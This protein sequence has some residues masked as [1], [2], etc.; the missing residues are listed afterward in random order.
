[1]EN[2]W[3]PV[4]EIAA[5]LG[6]IR[7][8]VYRWI[9]EKSVPGRKVGRHWKFKKAQVDCWVETGKAAPKVDEKT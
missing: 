4:E 5:H 3:F 7:D 2:R 6:V 9:D 8:K 1:V